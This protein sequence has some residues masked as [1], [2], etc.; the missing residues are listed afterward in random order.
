LEQ[1]GWQANR[2][3]HLLELVDRFRLEE[4]DLAQDHAQADQQNDGQDLEKQGE[5]ICHEKAS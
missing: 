5:W 1:Q 4:M 3:D 2:Q